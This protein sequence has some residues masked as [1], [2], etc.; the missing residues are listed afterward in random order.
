MENPIPQD[1]FPYRLFFLLFGPVALL[2]L[3]GAWYVGQDR[4]E[5][6]MG[7][8]RADEIGSVV[9]GVRRLDDELRLPLHQLRTLVQQ[10]AVRQAIDLGGADGQQ[11][12][13]DAFS[14]LIAYTWVYDKVRWIDETGRERVRVNNEAGRPQRVAEGGLQDLADSYYVKNTLQLKPGQFYISRLDLNVENGKVDIPYKPMLRLATPV[15]DS[16]GRPR[17]IL[18]LN[19]AARDLLNVFTESLVEARDH[20]MLV[21]S[22]GYWLK[23]PNSEDDWGFMFDREETLGSRSPAAWKAISDIPSGQ[24]EAADGLWTWSTVYPLKVEVHREVADTPH[25]LVVSHLP[26]NRLALVSRGAWNTVGSSGLVLLSLFGILAA[27]LTRALAGRT[28]A[29]VET[30]KAHV[31]TE[32][33]NRQSEVLKRFHLVVEAN[34][35]GLLAIDAQG[36]IV[37]V[38]PALERMF[39]YASKELLGL[40]MDIL[41]PETA[42]SRHVGQRQA[43]V[44]SPLARPMGTGR[45]L[46]GRRKDGSIFPVEIS[47]SPFTENGEQYVDAVVV[48]ITER[49]QTETLLRKS[50]AHLQ[51]LVHS[52]PNGLL[53]VDEEGHIDLANP[54]L[55]RLFGY[56]SGE[57]LGQP[58]ECLVPEAAQAGHQGLRR[59]YLQDPV[60]RPMGAGRRLH[61]R[62]KDGSTFPIEVSLASFTEEGRVFVQAT[63]VGTAG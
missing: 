58:V 12:M 4:I 22:D 53:V 44:R 15:E 26:S 19:V 50:E 36:R 60:V 17:G 1:K 2:I 29:E 18:V 51:M 47:L 56:E 14:G 59:Q 41:L 20:A 61:G 8:I 5:D 54:A 3:A 62:G 45:D 33:A 37:L 32:A 40:P 34:A 63:I 23:S 24:I 27:W 57:L 42:R 35:N 38:N 16:A 6:E 39:G 13:A 28:R 25:W 9:M 43:Y 31:E 30:A 10:D 55:E 11:G 7:L 48:D 21:N 49:K 52:N 46:Y